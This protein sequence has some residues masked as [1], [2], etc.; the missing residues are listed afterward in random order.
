MTTLAKI[1]AEHTSK[2]DPKT[3]FHFYEI[4]TAGK[5]DRWEVECLKEVVPDEQWTSHWCLYFLDKDKAQAEFNR[6][7][8]S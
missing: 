1:V 6:W 5:P 2:D 7:L 8:N 4:Q 3:S